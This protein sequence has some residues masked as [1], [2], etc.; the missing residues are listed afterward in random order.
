MFKSHHAILYLVS[1]I[2]VTP[3]DLSLVAAE[4]EIREFTS[5]KLS[6]DE[7]RTLIATAYTRPFERATQTIVLRVNDIGIEAQH[8]L[9]KVL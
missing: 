6:I 4:S 7:V 3:F 9:L 5:E 1:D 8:A 2:S